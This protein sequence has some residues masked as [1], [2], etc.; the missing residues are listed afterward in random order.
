MF[1]RVTVFQGSPEGYDRALDAIQNQAMPAVR[2]IPG[3]TAAYWAL[4]R[5][6]GKGI[7]FAIF[8][9]EESL[10]ASEETVRQIR[11]RAVAAAGAEVVSVEAYEIVGQI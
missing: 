6:T 10:R 1:T 11:E 3:V 4:D 9:S 5:A 2:Q 7:T 8:D